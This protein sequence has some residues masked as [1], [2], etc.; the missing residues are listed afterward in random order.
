M[1]IQ[2]SSNIS[3]LP[4]IIGTEKAYSK[5]AEVV[6]QDAGRSTAMAIYTLMVQDPAT[7][8]WNS[9]TDETATDGTELPQG[10]LMKAL[11]AAEIVAGDVSDVPILIKGTV[12]EQQLVIENSKT[13]ATEITSQQLTVERYLGGMGIYVRDT[14]AIDAFEN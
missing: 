13:L 8:K 3:N 5:D 7:E 6:V 12:D 10:I 11:T 1:A 4:F 2:A 9:F 14:T